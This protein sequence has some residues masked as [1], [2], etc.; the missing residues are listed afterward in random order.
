MDRAIQPVTHASAQHAAQKRILGN[1]TMPRL[2]ANQS[3]RRG[4]ALQQVTPDGYYPLMNAQGKD[5][6]LTISAIGLLAYACADIAHHG[7]GHATACLASGGRVVMLSSIFVDCTRTSMAIDLAGPGANLLIGVL[8]LLA[9][10][11]FRRSSP[12][13]RLFLILVAAFNLLWFSGH[14]MFSASTASDDWAWA[15][16]EVHAGGLIRGGMIVV[17]AL[18]YRITLRATAAELAQIEH[19]PARVREITLTVWLAAGAL[20]CATA[21]FDHHPLA[22]LLRSAAPQSLGTSV[23]LLFVSRLTAKMP[24][25]AD[26]RAPLDLSVPWVVAAGVVAVTSILLLGPGIPAPAFLR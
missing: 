11:V 5:S 10:R 17:G 6:L 14:L 1:A 21:A 25:S 20:A 24:G 7:L 12:A 18:L 26:M 3:I 8:A 4:R 2:G 13:T 16:Q 23:G 22:A 15:M 19:S 9:C